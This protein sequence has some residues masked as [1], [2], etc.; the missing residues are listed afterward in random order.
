MI[1]LLWEEVVTLSNS[2]MPFLKTLVLGEA[3]PIV[4]WMHRAKNPP[5]GMWLLKAY[6]GTTVRTIF[7][8]E[9]ETRILP[10]AV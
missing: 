3:H 8:A 5:S 2:L 6:H 9:A 7:E 4:L 10:L 1:S